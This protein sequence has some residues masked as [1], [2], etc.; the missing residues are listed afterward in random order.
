MSNRT[1]QVTI[2]NEA[3]IL[4]QMRIGKGLSMRKAGELI[5]RSDSYISQIENGRMNV[6]EGEVLEK[7]L[8]VYEGPKVRSFKERA[9]LLK[10]QMTSREELED[11]VKRLNA[12]KMVLVLNIVKGLLK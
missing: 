2:T 7:M 10:H 5:G 1:S 6:P 11:L 12:E 3:R 9:R 4:R 8:D